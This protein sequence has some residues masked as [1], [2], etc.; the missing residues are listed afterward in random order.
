MSG[1]QLCFRLSQIVLLLCLAVTLFRCNL[2]SGDVLPKPASLSKGE[3]LKDAALVTDV[4]NNSFVTINAKNEWDSLIKMDSKSRPLSIAGYSPYIAKSKEFS[5]LSASGSLQF[6]WESTSS[7]MVIVAVFK[8][9]INVSKNEIA[10]QRDIVW[11]WTNGKNEADVGSIKF[12]QGRFISYDDKG[13]ILV[14]GDPPG[15]TI[16]LPVGIYVWCIWTFDR[17]GVNVA[18]SSREIPFRITK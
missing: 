10:N 2:P 13:S 17:Y 6:D 14:P 5:A 4:S 1:N 3:K 7:K 18:S 8:N 15:K 16:G 12:S 9:V 11:L